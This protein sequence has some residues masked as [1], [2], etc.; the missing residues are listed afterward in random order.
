MTTDEAPSPRCPQ[1]LENPTEQPC[2]AC[3]EARKARALWEALERAERRDEEG[4]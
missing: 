2:R 3:G 1:H 4:V